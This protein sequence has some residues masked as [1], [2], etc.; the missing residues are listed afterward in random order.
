MT[1]SVKTNIQ[2]QRADLLSSTLSMAVLKRSFMMSTHSLLRSYN[3]LMGTKFKCQ[4]IY[5]TENMLSFTVRKRSFRRL[6]FYRCVSVHRGGH[7][8]QRC[9]CGGGR[10]WQGGV[11]GRGCAC[12]GVHAGGCACW[13]RAW[14]AWYGQWVGGTHPTGM[15]SCWEGDHWL[16]QEDFSNSR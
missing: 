8:W 14:C 13:G 4:I 11:H 3:Q 15:H 12:W 5:T 1:S 9:V 6:C 16:P 7:A 2:L 10:A